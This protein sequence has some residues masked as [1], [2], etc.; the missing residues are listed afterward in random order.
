M[1]LYRTTVIEKSCLYNII[2]YIFTFL[3]VSV[4]FRKVKRMILSV[5][6]RPYEVRGHSK[7]R[8]LILDRLQS[9][10]VTPTSTGL[11]KRVPFVQ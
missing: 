10:D 5:Y 1:V 4:N 11:S 9:L 6:K 2:L 7:V 8:Q 3:V